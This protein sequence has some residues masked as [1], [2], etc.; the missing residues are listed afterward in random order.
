MY[1]IN[2]FIVY[3]KMGVCRVTDITVP[4][5]IRWAGKKLYYV[6]QPL[7][8]NCV[9]YAPVD[10]KVFMRPIISAEDANRLIKAI[11]KMQ[12]DPYYNDRMQELVSHYENV[13][14]EHHCGDLLALAMSIYA[15]KQELEEQNHKFGQ[16]DGRY[17]KQAEELL[18]CELS[19]ALNIPMEKVPEYIAVQVDSSSMRAN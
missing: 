15:K 1:S 11:P 18:Y 16:I 9:I 5:N 10:T 8:G 13:L 14:H 4:N 6:L 3:G 2:D 17:L 12:T 19:L 7:Q